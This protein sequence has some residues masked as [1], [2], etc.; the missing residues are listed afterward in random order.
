MTAKFAEVRGTELAADP[1]KTFAAG[2]PL[3][4]ILGETSELKV[5]DFLLGFPTYDFNV[6]ELAREA[7]LSR[8]S[9]RLVL[10]KFLDWHILEPSG[11]R[12]GSRYYRLNNDSGHVRALREFLQAT[13]ELI[14][15]ETLFEIHSTDF[16][17]SSNDSFSFTEYFEE[18]SNQVGSTVN[19]QVQAAHPL[20]L[21]ASGISEQGY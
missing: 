11:V 19:T 1:P 14:V 15:G 21:V 8:P 4:G 6:S 7:E 17:L 12:A 13:N 18:L 10:Y 20:E 9:A 5:L 2:Q 16:S 3:G